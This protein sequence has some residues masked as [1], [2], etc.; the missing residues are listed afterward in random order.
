MTEEKKLRGFKQRDEEKYDTID[1]YG[2][3]SAPVEVDGDTEEKEIEEQ[4]AHEVE[5]GKKLVVLD[6]N[7]VFCRKLNQK[8][9][10]KLKA[11]GKG[12]ATS[13][14][15]APR[16]FAFKG[17]RTI[18]GVEFRQGDQEFFQTLFERYHVAIFSSTE[19]RNAERILN[20]VKN[21]K[22]FEFLWYRDRTRFDQ[23]DQPEGHET[24]KMLRDIYD[25]PVI[26]RGRQW[27]DR[28]TI[29]IDDSITKVRFNNPKNVLIVRSFTGAGESED[30]YLSEVL[31]M[32]EEKFTALDN[33]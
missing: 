15:S 13:R 29:I 6:I 14:D 22:R 30:G 11:S 28:N 4:V 18:G 20:Q 8:E 9:V 7:G 19:Q 33:Q 26:N 10:A 27:S 32:I 16:V 17:G 21:K 2:D 5:R 3:V 23:D 31:Q 12:K 25:N 24:V 1:D